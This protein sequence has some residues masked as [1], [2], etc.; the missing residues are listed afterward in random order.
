MAVVR[1][2]FSFTPPG[3]QWDAPPYERVVWR[4]NPDGVITVS[5]DVPEDGYCRGLLVPFIDGRAVNLGEFDR[6][7][8]AVGLSRGFV[9]PAIEEM[10]IRKAAETAVS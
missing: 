1:R 3:D 2:F 9:L 5:D 8:S 7:M 10:N 4:R 6:A